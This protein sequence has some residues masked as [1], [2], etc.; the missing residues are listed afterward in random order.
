MTLINKNQQVTAVVFG[1]TGAV[2][3]HLIEILSQKQPNWEILAVTRSA[4]SKAFSTL[5]NVKVVQGDPSKKEDVLQICKD[6]DIVYSCLG[7]A[8]YETKYW[9]KHWPIMIDNLLAGSSQREKDGAVQPQKF[10]M[11][12]NIYAYGTG[13][14]VSVETRTPVASSPKSKPGVRALLWEKFEAR[15]AKDPSSIVVV[16]GADFFGPHVT[17]KTFLGDTFTKAIL[18]EKGTP[19][20][21]GS[22][23]VIH[24]F[25]YVPDFANALY[26][27]GISSMADGKFWICPHSIKG[28][29]LNDIAADIARL[30]GSTVKK[31]QVY[32]GWSVRLLSPFV[33]FMREM[34]EML[35]FWQNNYTVDDS[36]FCKTFDVVATP[37]EEAL[38]VYIDYYKSQ[39][40]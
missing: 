38:K 10:V 22:A 5:S 31:V 24:D 25:C 9:A 2:G 11:C 3:R 14:N 23:S 30:N 16:G 29:S 27:A 7:F 28:K 6:A 34:I 17:D 39:S 36:A 13:E 40:S 26:L 33:G 18:S 21:L 15:M 37:Y 35:P 1:A 8:R 12:D 32:P 19:I 20:A 4:S